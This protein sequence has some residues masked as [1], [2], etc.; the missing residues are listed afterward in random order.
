MPE[1]KHVAEGANYTA[2][3]I[4]SLDELKDYSFTHPV[5]KQEV[6]GKVFIKEATHATGTEISFQSLS[7]HT[8]LSYFHSHKQNEESYVFLRGKGEFQVDD[9]CFPLK[10]GT[11]VR[12]SP[13][14]VRSLRNTSDEELVYIVIQSRE[15]SLEQ[16]SSGDGSRVVHEALWNK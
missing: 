15:G 9:S 8:E 16:Y 5:N 1:I 3:E 2:I 10:E 13:S 12:I 6:K 11:I 7:A 4:G 14:G